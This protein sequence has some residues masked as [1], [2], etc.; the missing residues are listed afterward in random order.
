M[1]TIGF[2]GLGI[3]GKPMALNLIK[4]GYDVKVFDINEKAVAEL[5]S[6]GATPAVS[7]KATAEG[8]DVIITMLPKSEH[9]LSVVLNENGIIHGAK[10]GSIVIDMSSITP[11]V[12]KQIAETL[13]A[14]GVHMMDAPVSGG[15][16]KAIDGTL[17]IMVG[18]SLTY[19]R[20]PFLFF[21]AWAHPL[22]S[23]AITDVARRRSLRIRSW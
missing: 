20:A 17:A 16:P 23:S 11:V 13:A 21:S 9:V 5:A 6:Q 4:G 7:P 22:P 10:P 1:K 14:S 18:A 2:I 15:E 3:M 8:S 12:S 19:L